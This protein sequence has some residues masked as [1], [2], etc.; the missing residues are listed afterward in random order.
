[1]EDVRLSISVQVLREDELNK[2]ESPERMRHR[3]PERMR[4]QTPGANETG[5]PGTGETQT[6]SAQPSATPAPT[7]EPTPTPVPKPVL[8]VTAEDYE[9]GV[10][11]NSPPMFT[12][13][14]HPGGQHRNTSTACLSA[15]S[16]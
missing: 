6:P 1:M 10:W 5:S 3:P 12:P 11:K 16:G 15:T 4:T 13:L 14:R 2:T 7:E 9:P 8:E